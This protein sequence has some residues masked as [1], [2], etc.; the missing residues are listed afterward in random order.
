LKIHDHYPIIKII[1]SELAD[2]RFKKFV[3]EDLYSSILPIRHEKHD[4]IIHGNVHSFNAHSFRSPDFISNPDYIFSG[5]SIT[6]GIG[7][8]LEK[9]WPEL[10][11][12][13]LKASYVNISASGDSIT[14]QVNK[15]FKYINEF[16]NPKNIIA[17]FPDFN[18]FLAF[19]NK[20]LMSSKA[21]KVKNPEITPPHVLYIESIS[22]EEY[23][24]RNRYL[25]R[26]LNLEQIIT[27]E[28]SSM[29]S[30]NSIHI[31]SQYC[32]SNGIN[33]VW[34]TWDVST[35]NLINTIL[36]PYPDFISMETDKWNY[37][38]ELM[39]DEYSEICHTEHEDDL[40]FH[41]ASDLEHGIEHA[42]FGSHRHMHY[43]DKFLNQI[44]SWSKNEN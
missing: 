14:G 1:S 44:K 30:S 38:L 35:E 39:K 40:F 15:I 18:R 37:N 13:E 7:L 3:L 11:I 9:I 31:L 32:K 21:F 19:N 28:I 43:A 20:S 8:P 34:S 10:I 25:K 26:P 2:Q 22:P 12:K 33:F 27:S 29:Y 17:L 24:D 4:Q 41:N 5:C 42:H 16:G 6:F 36:N 23:Q